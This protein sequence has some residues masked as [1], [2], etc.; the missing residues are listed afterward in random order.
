M[1]LVA[2]LAGCASA[3][4]ARAAKLADA[5][6]ASVAGCEFVGQVQGFSGGGNLAGSTGM[7]DA[8]NDARKEAA[9]FGA[10]HIVWRSVGGYSPYVRGQAYICNLP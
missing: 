3:L 8:R 7:E 5:D 9:K 10:T 1:T 2:F 6:E 4:S